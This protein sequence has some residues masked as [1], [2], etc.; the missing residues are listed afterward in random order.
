MNLTANHDDRLLM[1]PAERADV[2]VDFTD[3]PVGKYI[4]GNLGPDEPFGGGV[5]GVDFEPADRDTTGQVMEVRVVST[6]VSDDTTPP[7]FLTLPAIAPLP[8]PDVTR[9]LALIELMG[10]GRNAADEL[11]EGPVGALLGTV[12]A[13]R[14]DREA[15]D[16]PGHGEPR[17]WIH[18]G[19][20]VLQHDC[21][22]AP[23]THS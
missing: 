11:V 19:V 9:R 10:M 23:D 5:P 13:G 20:G 8:A 2:I 12:E 6:A 3:V 16:G 18:R 15:V 22:R 21:G 4:L 17:P 14:G 1:G 7:Q